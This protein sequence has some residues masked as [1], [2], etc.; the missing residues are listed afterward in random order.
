[1]DD[2]TKSPPVVDLSRQT[3]L[4]WN[5]SSREPISLPGGPTN[6]AKAAKEPAPPAHLSPY[7][8]EHM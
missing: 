1:M 7:H 5:D 4:K 8:C 6:Q 2:N 3:E